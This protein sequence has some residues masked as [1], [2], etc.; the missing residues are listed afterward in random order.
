MAA[1]N[2]STRNNGTQ[3]F[4]A[5]MNKAHVRETPTHCGI[6]LN[7]G[8]GRLWRLLISIIFTKIIRRLLIL[9]IFTKII[10]VLLISI[11]F[12]K[13]IRVLLISI[14][15]I[16]IIRGL[17]ISIIFTRIIR[18]IIEVKSAQMKKKVSL[19]KAQF[20]LR[21]STVKSIFS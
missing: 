1:P 17:L 20:G 7:F 10:R 9:I 21:K 18:S 19:A 11:I 16:K 12:M 15:S 14:I 4:C 13:I 8:G 3:C 2:C 6:F 5:C